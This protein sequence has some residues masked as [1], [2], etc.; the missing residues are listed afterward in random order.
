[1]QI[2]LCPRDRIPSPGNVGGDMH[3]DPASY[4]HSAHELMIS[5]QNEKPDYPTT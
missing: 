5:S 4:R 2:C 3:I 1:M